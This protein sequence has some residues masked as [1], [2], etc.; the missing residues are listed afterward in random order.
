MKFV[1]YTSIGLIIGFGGYACYRLIVKQRLVH[2]V[3]L[4]VPSHANPQPFLTDPVENKDSSTTTTTSQQNISCSI[5][6]TEAAEAAT[7]TLFTENDEK[8]KEIESSTSPPSITTTPQVSSLQSSDTEQQPPP[9]TIELK[10]Q[11]V[12]ETQLELIVEQV[13]KDLISNTNKEKE[14]D[15]ESKNTL[16]LTADNYDLSI[17]HDTTLN[18]END[19]SISSNKKN[20]PKEVSLLPADSSTNTNC[21]LDVCPS[22]PCSSP[23]DVSEFDGELSTIGSIDCSN[24]RSFSMTSQS[25]MLGEGM[26]AKLEQLLQEVGNLKETV[27]EMNADLVTVR[28]LEPKLLTISADNVSL[29]DE[30]NGDSIMLNGKDECSQTPSLEWDSN[31]INLLSDP[32]SNHST[33]KEEDE[34]L[35]SESLLSDKSELFSPISSGSLNS[36]AEPSLFITTFGDTSN[37]QTD[38][39][40]SSLQFSTS[41]ANENFV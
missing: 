32:D 30:T 4:A 34:S 19:L 11:K 5:I 15:G 13:V 36:T 12:K 35:L 39:E 38:K 14:T 21:S 3:K 20:G 16:N 7:A 9:L 18:C 24:Q 40:M 29:G 41:D 37:D 26:V 6:T 31:G 33:I 2:H 28:K 1:K 25:S 23:L 8:E 22:T 17:N 10:E 27:G